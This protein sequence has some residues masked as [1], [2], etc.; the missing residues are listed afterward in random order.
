MS[1]RTDGIRFGHTSMLRFSHEKT[2]TAY[3][4]RLTSRRELGVGGVEPFRSVV[5][6]GI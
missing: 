2:V 3:H 5:P 1:D 4:C 6:A